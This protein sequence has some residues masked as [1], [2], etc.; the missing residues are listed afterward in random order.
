MDEE[1]FHRRLE[2]IEAENKNFSVIVARLSAL[3]E[4]EGG[5]TTRNMNHLFKTTERHE[6][7]LF[8]DGNKD[9]G[10]IARVL[11]LEDESKKKQVSLRAAWTFIAG[12]A[13]KI[14]YDIFTHKNG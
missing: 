1:R 7:V 8:G 2:S 6:R 12:I 11:T 4:S 3:I 10:T 5:N 9:F 14:I 13:G